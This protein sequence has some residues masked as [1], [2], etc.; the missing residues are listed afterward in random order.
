MKTDYFELSKQ[1]LQRMV[2]NKQ[3]MSTVA[4]VHRTLPFSVPHKVQWKCLALLMGLKT[5]LNRN[6]MMREPQENFCVRVNDV[7]RHSDITK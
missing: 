1:S 3:L 4:T 2:N 6:L 5:P 7:T